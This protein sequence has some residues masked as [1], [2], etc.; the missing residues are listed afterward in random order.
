MIG[1]L[2]FCHAVTGAEANGFALAFSLPGDSVLIKDTVKVN[3][4]ITIIMN[5][6]K[7]TDTTSR[8]VVVNGQWL[9]K[10]ITVTEYVALPSDT[11]YSDAG[12]G[13]LPP[14]TVGQI[15]PET[16]GNAANATA[17]AP[18]AVQPTIDNNPTTPPPA[19]ITEP[20]PIT[21]PENTPALTEPAKTAASEPAIIPDAVQPTI[22]NNP[23]APPPAQITEPEPI[24]KPENTPALTEPAK[25]AAS[26][27]VLLPTRLQNAAKKGKKDKKTTPSETAKNQPSTIETAAQ[28]APP[29]V[30][31]PT[32]MP[33]EPPVSAPET[34]ETAAIKETTNH[35]PVVN[36][37]LN[38]DSNADAAGNISIEIIDNMRV[39][40]VRTDLPDNNQPPGGTLLIHLAQPAPENTKPP[41][42]ESEPQPK[43]N[44]VEPPVNDN[45]QPTANNPAPPDNNSL[46]QTNNVPDATDNNLSADTPAAERVVLESK[47]ITLGEAYRLTLDDVRKQHD[48]YAKAYKKAKSEEEANNILRQA[49]NY[50]EN[51]IANDIVYY[52]YGTGFDKEGTSANPGSGRIACSYFVATMLTEAGL[53]IDRIKLAQLSAQG[54]IKTL[55]T[56]EHLT[57]CTTPAEVE[58]L[59]TQKGK[60]LYFIGFSYHVGFLYYN[61]SEIDLIHASPLPP[62][63]VSRIPMKTARSFDY[64]NFYDIGKLTD[65]RD[66]VINWLTGKKMPIIP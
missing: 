64:S 28:T 55:S 16:P 17:N 24:T 49:G 56:P 45:N 48:F 54:I 12:T 6:L 65:N 47:T 36:N 42:K 57:R 61:G 31:Q 27:P 11:I 10:R 41:Q 34:K 43:L 8:P 3:E 9:K 2:F 21:K 50:L 40:G 4:R 22:D 52:W 62:G 53:N 5:T 63:T 15:L 51:I 44:A 13:S 23:T 59:I 14:E 26:E 58:S 25:T 38:T 18:V 35:E 66:L 19:Q 32:P 37:A 30:G 46:E 29:D 1:A 39:I 7:I 20:E 33:V 60:G